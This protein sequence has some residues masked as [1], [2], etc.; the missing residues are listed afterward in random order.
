MKYA[1]TIIW[2]PDEGE[3]RVLFGRFTR[4]QL[5]EIKRLLVDPQ[6]PSR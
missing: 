2:Y 3:V 4:E 6:Q 1:G 5:R